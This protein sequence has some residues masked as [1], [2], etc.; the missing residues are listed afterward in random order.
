[1]TED[2]VNADKV[3]V[4]LQVLYLWYKQGIFNLRQVK[5]QFR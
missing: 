3:G 5:N 4:Y 2:K 1:M